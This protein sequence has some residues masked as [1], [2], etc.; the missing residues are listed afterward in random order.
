MPQDRTSKAQNFLKEDI[1]MQTG[2]TYE[3]FIHYAEETCD[4]GGAI[5]VR[6]I[7]R[8]WFNEESS[9]VGTYRPKGYK[10]NP[11]DFEDQCETLSVKKKLVRT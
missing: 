8:S 7:S 1:A 3:D 6:K 2:M 10:R 4:L 5:A 11:L 9:E